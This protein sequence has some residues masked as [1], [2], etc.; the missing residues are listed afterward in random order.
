MF[1]IGDLRRNHIIIA[2]V[3][4]YIIK[5]RLTAEG[6]VI[7]HDIE[8]LPTSNPGDCLLFMPTIIE[9]KI[10]EQS[11]LHRFVKQCNNGFVSTDFELLVT[12]DGKCSKFFY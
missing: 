9:H 8:E 5:S 12:V 4:L 6:E 1:R 10:N 3:H 11:P 7:P 2:R